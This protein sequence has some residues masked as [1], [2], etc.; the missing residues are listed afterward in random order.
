SNSVD[1]PVNLS[2]NGHTIETNGELAWE[3]HVL[4]GWSWFVWRAGRWFGG[5]FDSSAGQAIAVVLFVAAVAVTIW[6]GGWGAGLLLVA[7]TGVALGVGGIIAGARARDSG[8]DFWDSFVGHIQDNWAVSMAIVGVMVVATKGIPLAVGGVK[9][10]AKATKKAIVNARLAKVQKWL[11]ANVLQQFHER[12]W[13]A[14]GSDIRVAK[15]KRGTSVNRYWD[16]GGAEISYWVTP[17]KY[18]NPVSSLALPPGSSA[19]NMSVL[20]FQK[21]TTV[22]KGTV[23]PNFGHSGGGFQIY[24]ADLTIIKPL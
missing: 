9:W 3:P 4:R 16:N 8:D 7:M 12:I 15:V 1:N 11:D 17:H 21:S 14:F 19:S 24:V 18:S 22:L 6:K 23:A 13:K 10:A 2:Y 20:T 5:L